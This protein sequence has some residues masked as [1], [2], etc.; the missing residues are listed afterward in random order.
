MPM[1]SAHSSRDPFQ[2]S[3]GSLYIKKCYNCL[4]YSHPDL[5][6][7]ISFLFCIL[8]SYSSVSNKI[9]IHLIITMNFLKKDDKTKMQLKWPL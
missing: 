6:L 8:I 7:L 1:S 4:K 5:G 3:K 2:Y 9:V